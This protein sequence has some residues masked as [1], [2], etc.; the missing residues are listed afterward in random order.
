MLFLYSMVFSNVCMAVGLGT[1]NHDMQTAIFFS[2]T[3]L[4]R[5]AYTNK[6]T[7][8]VVDFLNKKSKKIIE[9]GGVLSLSVSY[10]GSL[11][12]I[13][14]RRRL[15]FVSLIDYSTVLEQAGWF[16]AVNWSPHSN[17]AQSGR[18]VF[19]LDEM[20]ATKYEFLG[21]VVDS[22][23][24][25]NGYCVRVQVDVDS[26]EN[27][28]LQDDGGISRSPSLCSSGWSPDGRFHYVA[29][30]DTEIGSYIQLYENAG[31]VSRLKYT[32][33]VVK[34]PHKAAAVWGGDWLRIVGD[35]GSS[36]INLQTGK[37]SR[38]SRDIYYEN[39]NQLNY[40]KN[41][42]IDLASDRQR[43]VLLWHSIDEQFI[44]EDVVSGNVIRTYKRFW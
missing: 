17:V 15:T 23:S 36:M 40:K 16:D 13:A 44:V 14:G 30:E 6:S 26:F 29:V 18:F 28:M 21:R 39:D 35:Y 19:D 41:A 32:Y 8:Y 33:E 38:P 34:A 43:Y 1:Y 42:V 5:D 31:G 22:V 3:D 11:L 9:D 10:D 4:G 37:L 27:L 24:N 20:K 2:N 7:I 25:D 12:A